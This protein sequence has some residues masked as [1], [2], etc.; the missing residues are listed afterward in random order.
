MSTPHPPVPNLAGSGGRWVRRIASAVTLPLAQEVATL[1]DPFAMRAS[2]LWA[3]PPLDAAEL[4]VLLVG[5]MA[6]TPQSL[7]PLRDWLI[8]LN[9][10]PAISP[11]RFGVDCGERTADRVESALAELVDATGRRAAVVAH[12]RGGQ[13]ARAVAVRR[14][15]LVQGLV[16]LGS[17]VNRMLGIHPLLKAE[18]AML[19]LVG[20]LG[21][22]GLMRVACMW[23]ECC[24][25]LRADLQ[26]P[27]PTEVSF[28]SLYSRTDR[29]VDWRSCLDP[30]ARHREIQTTHSGLLYA[31]VALTALAEE[32]AELVEHHG[33]RPLPL[34]LAA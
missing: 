31:P 18:A 2:E 19:G 4:P 15:D 32:L 13:F 28:L 24:R 5:G 23:G 30:A 29:M 11:I 3:N 25:R 16:T 27:F 9:C 1:A 7:L 8:R 21:V 33:A 10:R 12:S 14:P 26:A 22:P 17:P 34:A 6:S 20:T